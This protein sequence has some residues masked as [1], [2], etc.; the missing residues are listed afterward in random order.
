M[1]DQLN[2]GNLEGF[3]SCLM[4]DRDSQAGAEDSVPCGREAPAGGREVLMR[5]ALERFLRTELQVGDM[6][7]EMGVVKVGLGCVAVALSVLWLGVLAV[8]IWGAVTA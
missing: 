3:Q 4:E 7:K 6:K 8:L 2:L 1:A 5:V